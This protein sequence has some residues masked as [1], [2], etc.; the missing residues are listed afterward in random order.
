MVYD[1]DDALNR[2][3]P[4]VNA[5]ESDPRDLET[6]VTAIQLA[7]IDLTPAAGTMFTKTELLE[8]VRFFDERLEAIDIEIVLDNARFLR[9]IGTRWMLK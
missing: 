8:R 3:P 2:E 6:I 7:A 9:K 5:H 1:F 4:I